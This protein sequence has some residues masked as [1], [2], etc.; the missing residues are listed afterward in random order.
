MAVHLYLHVPFCRAKCAYCAFCSQ[1]LGMNT[2]QAWA[3]GICAEVAL[4]KRRLA[5]KGT[6]EVR[7]IFMGG[8]TPS[9]VPP[10][11][12]ERIAGALRDAFT[13]PRGIEWTME[14]NPDSVD[15]YALADARSL[16]VSRLSLGLQSLDDEELAFLGRPH[17]GEQGVQAFGLARAAGFVNIS[18]DLMWGLPGQ[19]SVHWQRTLRAVA[20]EMRPEHISAYNLTLERDTPLADA[21]ERGEFTVPHDDEMARM[22]LHGAELLESQGYMQYEVS[23]YAR[24]GFACRHN[25]ACWQGRDYLGLGPSA[26]STFLGRRFENPRDVGQWLARVHDGSIGDGAEVLNANTRAREMVMLS[27][28]TSAGLSRAAYQTLTGHSFTARH[29]ALLAVLRQN[30]LVRITADAV[31]LTRQGQLVSNAIIARLF[32]T[33][34]E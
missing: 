28:R 31:R 21:Y 16:G 18:V 2:L 7:T 34:E 11:A 9:L 17:T 25:V 8:G 1:P 29:K 22:F 12:Y 20:E 10:W 23:N 19:R 33:D 5:A 6:P 30:D 4:W 3:D 13:I 26:V 24:M 15:R 14:A 32:G 27:L